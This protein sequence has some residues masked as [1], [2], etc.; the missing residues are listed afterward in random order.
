MSAGILLRQAARYPAAVVAAVRA[1]RN[2][3]RATNGLSFADAVDV[4]WSFDGGRLAPLQNRAEIG[5]LLELL[6]AEQPQVVVEIGTYAGGT[7]F[8]WSRVAAPDATLVAIDIGERLV[9]SLSPRAI[10][11][12]GFAR[13]EQRIH[14][15]FGRNSNDPAT[16]RR[17]ERLLRG[18]KIDFL[19]IDGDHTYEGVRADFELF[20]DLVRPGGLIAFHDI[21]HPVDPETETAPFWNDFKAAHE[22]TEIVEP[23]PT[24]FGIGLYRPDP[25]RDSA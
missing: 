19:F 11:C 10:F 24:P 8:F 4:A 3:R 20:E 6:A 7:L 14:T 22:T 23:S 16:R 2:L 13:A 25:E 18:R 1:R 12:R 9:R 15:L 21:V 5:A 17:L